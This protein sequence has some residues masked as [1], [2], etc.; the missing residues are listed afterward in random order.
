MVDLWAT[1]P[2]FTLSSCQWSVWSWSLDSKFGIQINMLASRIYFNLVQK[3]SLHSFITWHYQNK[4]TKGIESKSPLN[5]SNTGAAYIQVKHSIKWSKWNQNLAKVAKVEKL[6][7][8]EIFCRVICFLYWRLGNIKALRQCQRS[9]GAAI[10]SL[11]VCAVPRRRELQSQLK[12]IVIKGMVV[13]TVVYH[14]LDK[15]RMCS[16]WL[17]V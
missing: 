15:Q 4:Q 10:L 12:S 6:P 8:Q 3:F 13:L 5:L 1:S 7:T 11:C 2:A 17:T 16:R 14:P 9:A